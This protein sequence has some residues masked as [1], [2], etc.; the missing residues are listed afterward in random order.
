MTF[1][2]FFT[3]FPGFISNQ[4]IREVL[5]KND[6]NGKVYVLVLPSMAE[7]A[8]T[9]RTAILKDFG[10]EDDSFK[11]IT[12]DITQNGLGIG[13]EEDSMLKEAV[14][15]VFHLAAIYDLAVPKDL[16]F[17]VNVEGTR[18]V[19]E[20]VKSLE[21]IKRYTYFSTAFVA[22]KREGLLY[23]NELIRPDAFKNF[24]EETKYEAEVLVEALKADVPVTIIRPGIVKGH[25]K[26][27]ET[28]KFDGPYF[29]MNFIDRLSFMPF[30][31]HLGKGNTVVNLVPVDYII[32]ATTYL[33]FS[34]KGA[35]KTYHLT[36]P[37]PYKVSELYEMMMVELLRKQP[38]GSV[39]LALA[40]AGLNFRVLRRYL[41][42]EKEALDY[43]TWKGHF[44]SSQ[45]QN[46]LRDSGIHCPDF[47]DGISAMASFYRQ[48]KHEPHYQIN[49]L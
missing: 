21:H 39:P 25:S 45:A 42:V 7:K 49:I 34:E 37:K 29:I 40:K 43:F 18:H 12:G 14:T 11:I 10:M 41:G 13:K 9:E 26:T 1:G 6:G 20:W 17:R 31:P 8:E 32:E 35:G 48:N 19:N 47:K 3:G 2:Y 36:D 22:G 33:T 5:R 4:L 38:K 23:E 15:H 46:D 44:D 16:A 30:L 28:I 27:G 24:Y